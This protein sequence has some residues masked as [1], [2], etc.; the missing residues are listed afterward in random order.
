MIEEKKPA[1]APPKS[2]KCLIGVP[3]AGGFLT[4]T[5]V[6]APKLETTATAPNAQ[7]PAEEPIPA[8]AVAYDF[9][10]A[11]AALLS[12]D[13]SVPTPVL[14]YSVTII[15]SNEKTHALIDKNRQW[16][17]AKLAELHQNKTRTELNDPQVEKSILEQ[18][19]EQANSL[20][21]R[22]QGNNPDPKIQVLQPLHLKF[23]IF[24]L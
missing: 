22:L 19:R 16:F 10:E 14:V 9:P 13:P 2:K 24:V 12:D 8:E 6:L 7:A 20:L 11:Q 1:Q 3:G 17:V 23:P 5:F 18:T 21:R 15:C 4:Y